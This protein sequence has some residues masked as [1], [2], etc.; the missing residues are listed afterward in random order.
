[1]SVSTQT[2]CRIPPFLYLLF[3]LTGNSVFSAEEEL[4][5]VRKS[6]EY[7]SQVDLYVQELENLERRFGPYDRSLLEPLDALIS[8]HSSVDDFAEI[9]SL[10][11]RQLQLVHVTE[12]PNAFSQLPILES[13]IRNNLEIKN[14]ESVTNNFE[15]RQYVFLQNPDSTVEQKLASMDDLRNW[16]LTAFNLDTKQNRLPYFMKSRILLQQMLAVASDAYEEKEERMVPLLYKEALEKYYLMTLL[17]SVDELGYDANDFIFVP[18]RIQPMTYLRQGYEVVKDI[19]DIIRLNG[20]KE[21]E[22]MATVYEAD[23]QMLLGLGLARRTYQKAMD[24]FAEAGVQEQKIIDFFSRPI[25]IPALEY[26]TSIDDAMSAQAADGYVYTEGE[27]G[28]DPKI[29]LGNY[30]AWNESVPFTPMPNPPNMLSDIE[31][32]LMRVDTRFR[33]SSRGK[34][35]GPDAET[36]DPESVRARR[37]AE[38]ALK[39][40]VFRPRF[41]G[42]RWRPIRNLTMTYWYPTEK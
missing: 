19:S 30:T 7:T 11:G 39:E 20:D 40:M 25:V 24:L 33:I 12:G 13:L 37:D 42:T 1:M 28:E 17:T 26:Y 41:I 27:D 15:N 8:L 31:L 3:C 36:S 14:F 9:N 23:Y 2:A 38:D 4:S 21:A 10:L 16:Y 35:R 22:G 29:H 34:T 18:E 5:R 6:T 32:G